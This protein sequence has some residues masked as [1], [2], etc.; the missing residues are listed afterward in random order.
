M[1]SRSSQA[2]TFT[3]TL[4]IANS[5]VN[6]EAPSGGTDEKEVRLSFFARI[7]ELY[8]ASP[9]P[10]LHRHLPGSVKMFYWQ[11][12]FDNTKFGKDGTPL[13]NPLFLTHPQW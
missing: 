3:C 5:R 7:R 2:F 1:P 4:Y 12:E 6:L 9:W 8:L 10:A 13:L 11:G